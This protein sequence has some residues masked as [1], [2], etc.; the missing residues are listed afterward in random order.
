[1]L[2]LDEIAG[3]ISRPWQGHKPALLLAAL[4]G[5]LACPVRAE[6]GE[7]GAAGAYLR[8]GLGAR[9][10][11]MG[12]S[13]VAVSNDAYASYWNPAGLV[14]VGNHQ[15]GSMYGAMALER[16]FYHA[17]YAHGN[18]LDVGVGIG[19][20]RFGVDEIEERDTQGQL[21]GTFDDAENTYSLSFAKGFASLASIGVSA[22]Y[23]THSLHDATAAGFGFDIGLLVRPTEIVS[24]G[25][26]FQD[27]GTELEWDTPSDHVDEYPLNIR[28]GAA[29]RLLEGDLIIAADLEKNE[30]QAM[31]FHGGGEYTLAQL[32]ALRVGINDKRLTAGV[33]LSAKQL[34]VDYAYVAD[35]LEEGD[36]SLI[37]LTLRF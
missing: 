31:R 5:T 25:L 2:C 11:G 13:Y 1:M 28:G 22:K 18:G 17:S 3:A 14:Q 36:S 26:V 9:P 35:K 24:I 21:L 30:E 34:Q 32:L 4:I 27:I 23:L 8:M 10:M 7:A 16:D 33:G 20:I 12:G 6:E 15:I 29:V 19:W 37:S